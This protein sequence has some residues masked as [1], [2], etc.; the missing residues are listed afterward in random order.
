MTHAE[1]MKEIKERKQAAQRGDWF[2]DGYDI[3]HAGESY[4][5]KTDPHFYTGISIDSKLTKSPKALANLTFCAHARQDI[6][7]LVARVEELE[8]ALGEAID[9]LE[10]RAAIRDD[11]NL[12][13]R[14]TAA[15]DGDKEA[16][17]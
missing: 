16:D 8:A 3:W 12:L 17:R 7:Y 4:E 14:L 2:C 1:R 9:R 11:L 5:S 10:Q 13:D 6:P 15:R